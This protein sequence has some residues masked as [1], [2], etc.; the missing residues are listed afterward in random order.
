MCYRHR[1]RGLERTDICKLSWRPWACFPFACRRPSSRPTTTNTRR[2]HPKPQSTPVLWPERISPRFADCRHGNVATRTEMEVGYALLLVG[3]SAPWAGQA[4]SKGHAHLMTF[5]RTRQTTRIT[6]VRLMT[7]ER[8]RGACTY[9]RID[10][11]P[12]Y[13]TIYDLFCPRPASFSSF[14]CQ[15]SALT[16]PLGRG[17]C[18]VVASVA[19]RLTPT[20]TVGAFPRSKHQ[21]TRLTAR[22]CPC[23]SVRSCLA[24]FSIF[25][26]RFKGHQ[27]SCPST[28][29][30]N[31]AP[32]CLKARDLF[33]KSDCLLQGL[34]N[35]YLAFPNISS[36]SR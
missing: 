32:V 19:R 10:R 6:Q 9:G 21:R 13:S 27:S 24:E 30:N 11:Y 33:P 5:S 12:R 31:P 8:S 25:F 36:A 16:R 7:N 17:N 28:S 29:T 1:Q 2:Q 14:S 34:N 20:N 35:R 15:I 18:L 22:G 26:P 3:A 23:L 4:V